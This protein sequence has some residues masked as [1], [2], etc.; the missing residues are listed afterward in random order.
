M[1]LANDEKT[2]WKDVGDGALSG[3]SAAAGG[4]AVFN[5]IPVGGQVA[6][7]TAVAVGAVVG[8]AAV[9][10][11]LFSET[12]CA[13]DPV[14]GK[15]ACCNISNLSNIDAS[16]MPIGG[17]MFCEFPGVRTCVQGKKE[18]E[19]EQS[20]L[21]GRFLDD[22]WSDTCEISFCSGYEMP[23][24]SGSFN[25]Q[26]YGASEQ[27]NKLCWKWE[28]AD[29]G[30]VRQG[31]K[32][33]KAG[34]KG[35]ATNKVVG[36]ACAAA[37]LP[38]Y[39]TAGHY[40]KSGSAVKCAATECKD[41]TYLVVNG[42]G[43]SQGWCS[44]ATKCPAGQHFNI[45]DGKKTDRKCVSDNPQKNVAAVVPVPEV[46]PVPD[47]ERGADN[48]KPT[49][50][51]TPVPDGEQG[52]DNAQPKEQPVQKKTP[53]ELGTSGYVFFEGACITVVERDAILE[54]RAAAERAQREA[55]MLTQVKSAVGNMDAMLRDADVS[56]WKN[57]DGE[58]NTARLAS[59]SIA[60]VVL[61]TVG[62]IVTN[63]V[64]KKNQVEQ[65]FEDIQCTI[66]GQV[67]ADW[68]D[69]FIIQR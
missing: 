30:F 27:E 38:Q 35:A 16:R 7:G 11:K 37:D 3:G 33:V 47:G 29:S 17:Q 10:A 55:V 14:T 64:I 52:A 36:Q 1:T 23:D 43:A 40:I 8:G 54:Q 49:P 66:G 42:S 26:R 53:C 15:W 45:I 57:A 39:A 9:G 62:G 6:Y 2:T 12:D 67:V 19:T 60:G 21:K 25:I 51:Q 48:V 68:G 59:D 5:V 50:E 69:E 22:H 4:A 41:G 58:F 28:C 32:C 56:V 34:A 24:A 61:G 31:N 13:T 20:W 46:A 65:G 63:K 18:F 44:A